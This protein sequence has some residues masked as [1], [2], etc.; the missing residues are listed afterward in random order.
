M[1]AAVGI[2]R[3]GL[4]MIEIDLHR[5]G[6]DWVVDWCVRGDQ[7][8]LAPHPL[9]SQ[10]QCF[11]SPAGFLD[12]VGFSAFIQEQ[13]CGSQFNQNRSV[14]YIHDSVPWSYFSSNG[15]IAKNARN[16]YCCEGDVMNNDAYWCSLHCS[17]PLE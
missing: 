6:S 10:T 15:P 2:A 17:Y 5:W 3:T 11:F 13:V 16:R 8:S 9:C 14:H 12:A 4:D 1:E 7:P